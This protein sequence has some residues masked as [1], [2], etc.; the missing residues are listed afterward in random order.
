MI[1]NCIIFHFKLKA[2]GM[3]GCLNLTTQHDLLKWH[4]MNGQQYTTSIAAKVPGYGLLH[5]Q[6]SFMMQSSLN[7]IDANILIVG[8]GGGQEIL[9][10]SL[11]EGWRF[12][13]IDPSEAMLAEACRRL[14]EGKRMERVTF[15]EGVVED[16]PESIIYDGATCMLVLHFIQDEQRKLQLLQEIA[17]R[18]R[19]GAMFVMSTLSA[20][21]AS[22]ID[23]IIMSAYRKSMLAAGVSEEHWDRFQASM[24]V[25][26]FPETSSHTVA[27]L[28]Q[29]GFYGVTRYFSSYM[30]EGYVAFKK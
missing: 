19:S 14:D 7:K 28:E 17:K 1:L 12:T 2:R 27:L 10:L 20:D 15:I 25:T 6:M 22:T 8:A 18:L 29:A 3:G 5:E 13:G 11:Q 9:T 23:P 26:Y 16:L 30:A 21:P 24:G 4:Q